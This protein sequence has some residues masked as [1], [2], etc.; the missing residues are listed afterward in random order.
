MSLAPRIFR[1]FLSSTFSDFI[2]EREALRRHVFPVLE[3]HC[4]KAGAQFQAVDL[5]WGITEEA[6]REHDTMRICLEEVRRCQQLSPK[7]NFA[8][9]LGDRYGWEPVP[10]R[11][12]ADH[13]GRL[14]ESAAPADWSLIKE[15]YQPDGNAIPP[16]YCLSKRDGD[17]ARDMERESR[18]LQALR[19]AVTR[20]RFRG[21]SRL[22]YF[23]SA[24]HQE[25]AHGALAGFD[26]RR[27]ALHPEQHVH[28]YVRH[29]AGLPHDESAKDFIDW[30]ASQGCVVPGARERLRDLER[31]LRRK[32]AG[33]VH[34]LHTPWSRHGSNGSVNQAYLKRFCDAF[35]AHQ[36]ALID[37]QLAL[38]VEFDERELRERAHQQFGAERARVFVGREELLAR[39][40]YPIHVAKAQTHC[41]QRR[42]GVMTIQVSFSS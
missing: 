30:D 2:P 42:R 33:R 24:T 39:P 7:P 34:D 17:P 25:I 31:Q 37:E 3:E 18:L 6:Q 21:S 38:Q 16:V 19:R 22:T 8:V 15:S 27:R 35:L 4:A 40:H 1:L 26:D 41:L 10:A 11:I 14:R 36:K 5:R 13:W 29:L 23:A 9:L 28:V 20:A 12:R 32:L